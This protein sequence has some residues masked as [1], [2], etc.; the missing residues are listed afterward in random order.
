MYQEPKNN[1]TN[2]ELKKYYSY[3]KQNGAD[4]PPDYNSF[5]STLKDVNASKQYYDY[6]KKEGFDAPDN[7]DAFASTFGLKKKKNLHNHHQFSQ[8]RV[9]YPKLVLRVLKNLNI[10]L[11]SMKEE[12]K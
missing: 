3:L 4:V 9:R 1:S 11:F 2:P 7:Y 8:N 6:L 10:N 12:D 5:E